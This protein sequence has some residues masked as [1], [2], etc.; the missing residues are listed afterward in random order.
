[1][2]MPSFTKAGSYV[3]VWGYST[4]PKWN[5]LRDGNLG[6]VL[7]T[8]PDT[9]TTKDGK[10]I[11]NWNLCRARGYTAEFLKKSGFD[12]GSRVVLVGRLTSEQWPDRNNN[13]TTDKTV[14]NVTTILSITNKQGDSNKT[15]ESVDISSILEEPDDEDLSELPF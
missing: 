12:Q 11:K 15:E 14:V 5:T 10:E 2:N 8:L 3:M 1:M 7:F 4:N 6:S 9:Y 13:G